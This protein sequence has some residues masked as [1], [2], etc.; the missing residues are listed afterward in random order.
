MSDEM[1]KVVE[2][3]N[4]RASFVER[5][6]EG[7]KKLV[8]RGI[9]FQM[10]KGES[11]A[12]VGESGSGK[13]VTALSLARLLAEPPLL[14]EADVMRVSGLDVLA[15][16]EEELRKLRGKQVGYIFQEPTTSLN[17]VMSIKNQI[18]E[19]LRLHRPD[20][21]NESEEIKYWLDAVG[22]TQV[23]DRLDCYPYQ[24]SGGMQQRVMIAMALCAR[25]QLLIADEPT[26]ALDVT[27]QKQIMKLLGELRVR[28]QMSLL[29]I[30]HNFGII[31][32][33]AD[34]VAVM[35][36]GEIVEFGTTEKVLGNPEH[37]YTK[38]LIACVPKVLQKQRRLPTLADT[39]NH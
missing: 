32:D 36:Q 37:P 4:F 7:Q 20:V 5:G 35:Y 34:K 6:F 26:T 8:V 24:L 17:P 19:S 30:T 13:S 11:I 14:L 22:I 21:K 29:M 9:D 10:D 23:E 12:L 27:I 38:G 2:L 18:A 25:P 31:R 39:M 33:V 1:S 15:A 28:Y 16:N 3:K